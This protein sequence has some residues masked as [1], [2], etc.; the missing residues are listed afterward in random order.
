MPGGRAIPAGNQPRNNQSQLHPAGFDP[1]Q[2]APDALRPRG[3][4]ACR[5]NPLAIRAIVPGVANGRS[6]HSMCRLTKERGAIDKWL[7][8]PRPPDAQSS[9][10]ANHRFDCFGCVVNCLDS[11][12]FSV[13]QAGVCPTALRQ[14]TGV[15][16]CVSVSRLYW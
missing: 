2:M 9:V 6:C 14:Q 16:R 7:S 12:P 3:V 1:C 8:R 5:C 10:W 13:R 11:P 4:P 15:S